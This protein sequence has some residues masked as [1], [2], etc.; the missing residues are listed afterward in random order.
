MG[1]APWHCFGRQKSDKKT[2]NEKYG[3]TLDGWHSMMQHTTTNQKHV[4]AME[5][6]YER[7]CDQGGACRGAL[8]DCLEGHSKLRGGKKLK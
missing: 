4:G 1:G 2:N 8:H 7:R 6:V 3:V 5:Q